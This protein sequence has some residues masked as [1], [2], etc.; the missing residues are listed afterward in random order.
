[1]SDPNTLQEALA[2]EHAVIYG[3][4][5]AGPRLQGA[6]RNAADAGFNAHRLRRERLAELVADAGQTPVAP[7]AAYELP[8]P[9]QSGADARRL[10]AL[11]EA[12]ISDRY[13]DL[14]RTAATGERGE[15]VDWL[16]DSAAQRA[17]FDGGISAFPGAPRP[18]LL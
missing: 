11:L 16:S 9:V 14:V 12:G 18:V 4:G 8:F 6:D 2:D 17:R 7:A 10:I 1:M 5:V 15:P 13:Y 3:Y